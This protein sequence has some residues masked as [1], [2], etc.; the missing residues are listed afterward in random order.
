MAEH[1]YKFDIAMSCGGCSGAVERVL[2]KL[3]GVKSYDVSLET[4]SATIVTEDSLNY[5]TVLE[6]IKKTGK[7]VKSGQA[8]GE[9]RDI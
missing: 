9:A 1:T 2:K 7:T 8:D 3:D 4:Q 5:E 6:K